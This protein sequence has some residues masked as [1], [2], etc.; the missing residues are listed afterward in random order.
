MERRREACAEIVIVG[1]SGRT[2]N[3]REM[4]GNGLIPELV[5]RWYNEPFMEKIKRRSKPTRTLAVY[6]DYESNENGDYT[7]L[8]GCPVDAVED[9]PEGLTSLVI[10][11]AEYEVLTTG[12]GSVP[13]IILEAWGHIWNDA[14]LKSRRAYTYDFEVYAK[15][16]RDPSHAIVDLYIAINTND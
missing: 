3:A 5:S 7:Y 8:I 2:N 10:P 15:A 11:P 14:A 6:T 13:S 9:M 4:E 12:P 1:L 16:A